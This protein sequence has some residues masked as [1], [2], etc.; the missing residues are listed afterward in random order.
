MMLKVHTDKLRIGSSDEPAKLLNDARERAQKLKQFTP[1]IIAEENERIAKEEKEQEFK[2]NVFMHVKDM[3]TEEILRMFPCATYNRTKLEQQKQNWPPEELSY[4]EILFH[5]GMSGQTTIS[6]LQRA[7]DAAKQREATLTEQVHALQQRLEKEQAT[8]IPLGMGEL[9]AERCGRAERQLDG[10]RAEI[11]ALQL[12]EITRNY[13]TERSERTDLEQL[14]AERDREIDRLKEEAAAASLRQEDAL[15]IREAE[16]KEQICTL[17]AAKNQAEQRAA[18]YLADLSKM[19]QKE[20]EKHEEAEGM[21]ERSKCKQET[22][23]ENIHDPLHESQK[24]KHQRIIPDDFN[25]SIAYF[26]DSR[27]KLSESAKG[28]LTI[29]NLL[30]E[31]SKVYKM[32]DALSVAFYNELSKELQTSKFSGIVKK[33]RKHIEGKNA[34]VYYR[35]CFK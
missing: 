14:L 1:E 20:G 31:F 3:Y 2:K 26:I 25:R 15:A 6:D 5:T 35:L 7:L 18:E 12:R 34:T 11:E 21:I 13:A 22:A 27:L 16:V 29:Y 33:G 28:F 30:N 10:S 4:A 24:R 8:Q 23:T 17:T 9:K 19:Q 32:D